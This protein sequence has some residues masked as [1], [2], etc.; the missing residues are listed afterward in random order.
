MTTNHQD[1]QCVHPDALGDEDMSEEEIKRNRE[2]HAKAQRHN[3]LQNWTNGADLD[4]IAKVYCG[5]IN[6]NG[7][8]E[9][10]AADSVLY[11]LYTAVCTTPKDPD[12]VKRWCETTVPRHLRAKWLKRWTALLQLLRNRRQSRI[13][14]IASQRTLL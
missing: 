13:R 6:T 14:R 2:A 1:A 9:G 10:I 7:D 4:I 8:G 5:G 12:V 11:G 3:Q